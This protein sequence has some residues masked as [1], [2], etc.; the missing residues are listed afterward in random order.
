MVTHI[1][2]AGFCVCD[3]YMD[4]NAVVY[5]FCQISDSCMLVHSEVVSGLDVAHWPLIE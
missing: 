4:I 1:Y 5:I 2:I 3:T